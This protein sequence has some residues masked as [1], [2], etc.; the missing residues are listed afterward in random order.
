M[1][2]ECFTNNAKPYLR[3]V[4]S[5][6][7]TNKAGK[8]IPQKQVVLNLGP[9]DRFDDGQPDYVDRLKKS[10]KSG[11]PLIPALF[12][13][14]D[15]KKDSETYR[16]TL[17]EGSPDCFGHPKLFS[18]ILMER[19]LEELGLNTFFHLTKG[20]PDFSTMF[21]A[22]PNFSFSGASYILRQNTQ[23]SDKTKIISSQSLL[24]LTRIM[25]M[26]PSILLLLIKIRSSGGSIPIWLKKHTVPLKSSTMM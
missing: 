23:P 9:L 21:M 13:Y 24:T 10:F 22:L 3:L 18:H 17:N 6:R 8:K 12:P 16:F 1:Y 11:P 5:V 15:E 20:S 4:Q 14:C 19:I 2:V 7:V 26:I 25:F